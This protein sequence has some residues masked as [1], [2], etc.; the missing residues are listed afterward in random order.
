M[1][2]T[3]LRA[4]LV[5]FALAWLT[6]P[7]LAKPSKQ[8]I[9]L[10]KKA[11]QAGKK[12]EKKGEWEDAREAW[13][14]AVDLNDTPDSRTHLAKAE[15]KLGRLLL[16]EEMLKK[17][18]EEKKLSWAVR[19]KANKQLKELDKQIPQ[20]KV[21]PPA[22]FKGKIWVDEEEVELASLSEP[23]R[24][25]PGEHKIRAEAEGYKPFSESIV[26]EEGDRKDLAILMTEAPEP[27]APPPP[28]PA[29][30]EKA[31]G[32]TQRT[33]GWVSIGVGVIG[34]GVG[35]VF[36]IQARSTRSELDDSCRDD[37]CS[38]A[39]RELYDKGKNQANIAT[40]GFIVGGVGI[41]LGTVLLLTAG[42]DD[43]D[44]PKAEDARLEPVIGPAHV[45]VRGVF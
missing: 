30:E 21:E 8:D 33:L 35:T 32:S 20:L 27:I 45:G 5:A 17:V 44:D 36:A 10:S 34:A 7:A 29:K 25:D 43:G 41:G 38:E 9:A 31:S 18:L 39:D 28:K 19:N 2:K 26:L 37:V 22:D 16:A 3:L 6:A 1:G 11:A 23:L 12:H 40:A 13:Q 15:A 4:L 42:S 24:F 14:K